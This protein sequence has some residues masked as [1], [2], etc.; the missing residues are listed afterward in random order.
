MTPDDD[1]PQDWGDDDTCNHCGATWDESVDCAMNGCPFAR[2]EHDV[3]NV[4]DG[5]GSA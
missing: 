3:A 1:L 5:K 2:V 4:H